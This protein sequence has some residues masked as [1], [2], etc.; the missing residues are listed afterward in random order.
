M[1]QLDFTELTRRSQAVLACEMVELIG[2]NAAPASAE[3]R[4]QLERVAQAMRA[5][6]KEVP[7]S[8]KALLDK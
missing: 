7:D 1:A 2:E 8:I 3:D 5:Q 6:D 4:A